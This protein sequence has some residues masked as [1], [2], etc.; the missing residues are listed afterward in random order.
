[1]ANSPTV[2]AVLARLAAIDHG[3]TRVLGRVCG[4]PGETH[5]SSWCRACCARALTAHV[6]SLTATL[7]AIR[8]E[9]ERSTPQPPGG[10][11]V[12]P[13]P[14]L[15][16]MSVSTR[17]ALVRLLGDEALPT[18]VGEEA[19]APAPDMFAAYRYHPNCTSAT[20]WC[21]VCARV[22][23]STFRAP[24]PQFR[25]YE[26]DVIAR[27]DPSRDARVDA[28]VAYAAGAAAGREFGRGEGA[29]PS[30]VALHAKWCATKMA[31]NA[32]LSRVYGGPDEVAA[33]TAY[34]SASNDLFAWTPKETP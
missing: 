28:S 9:V 12:G 27:P 21:P 4:G 20:G 13:R 10:Q 22:Q 30:L 26:G 5:Q 3:C 23:Q 31:L 18:Q 2:A 11:Q 33:F 24:T 6:R 19:S 8:A 1:M 7:D 17:R 14:G 15:W 34:A 16:S 29:P 25:D 32:S